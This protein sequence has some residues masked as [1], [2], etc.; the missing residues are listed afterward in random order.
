MHFS[1]R[2]RAVPGRFF[3]DTQSLFFISSTKTS[4]PTVNWPP[5]AVGWLTNAIISLV[6]ALGGPTVVNLVSEYEKMHSLIM[7]EVPPTVS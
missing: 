7:E 1:C 4:S 5:T 2:Q 6:A 3:L